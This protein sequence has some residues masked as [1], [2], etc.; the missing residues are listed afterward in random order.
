MVLEGNYPTNC[1]KVVLKDKYGNVIPTSPKICG[2]YIN[3]TITFELIDT[4]T[5]NKCWGTLIVEDKLGPK[6]E[7]QN[8]DTVFCNNTGYNWTIPPGVDNC[9]GVVKTIVLSDETTK[10]PCDSFC[11]ARRRI[12]YY[13][14]DQ[15]GNHSDTCVKEICFKKIEFKDI[16]WPKDTA[17][18]CE[19]WDTIPPPYVS[20]VPT[21]GGYPLYPD[22]F[23]AKWPLRMKIN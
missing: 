7:C 11:I 15:Y 17:Y 20:G 3:Q 21:A 9:G 8:P 4:C 6:I 22:W 2:Q 1:L 19:V 5:K 23:Y 18:S 10:L 16:V 12:T 14:Q 13:Y